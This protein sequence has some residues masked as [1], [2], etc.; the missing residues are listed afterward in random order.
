MEAYLC[1]NMTVLL[2]LG[3]ARPRQLGF[4]LGYPDQGHTIMPSRFSANGF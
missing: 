1:R 2:P 3:I 4:G